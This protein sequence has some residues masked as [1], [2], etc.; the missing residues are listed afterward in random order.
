VTTDRQRRANRD[1]AKASTGPKTRTGK[2][3]SAQNALR[4]AL[5]I[6]V[7]HDP[8]LAAQA[9]AIARK[10]AGPNADAEAVEWARR[11]GEA[12][13]DLNRTRARRTSLLTE[14][15]AGNYLPHSFN[16]AMMKCLLL[17]LSD[18]QFLSPSQ[19]QATEIVTNHRPLGGDEKLATILE[20]R[21][22]EL[23]RLDRYERRAISKRKSAVRGFDSASM[24]GSSAKNKRT[25]AP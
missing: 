1:N 16:K 3:H 8:T 4:H 2:L 12:Q 5:N 22:S 14:L 18:R 17:I 11:I 6:P 9:A 23:A 13:I 20:D 10:I 24:S 15:L 19:Q 21:S 7:W 25:D